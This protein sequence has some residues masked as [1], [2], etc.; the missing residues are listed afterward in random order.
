MHGPRS[1]GLDDP[2]TFVLFFLVVMLVYHGL[3]SWTARKVFLLAASYL[4]HL[5][6]L[7]VMGCC[8]GWVLC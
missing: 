5:Q 1:P 7:S 4:S 2:Y 6:N 3:R 8:H